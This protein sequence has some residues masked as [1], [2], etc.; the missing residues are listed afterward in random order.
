MSE[1]LESVFIDQDESMTAVIG[2]SYLQNFL[3]GG[4]VE[5][6]VGILTQKRFYYKGTNFGGDG[7][8]MKSTTEEGVVS[9]EDITFTMF[10]HTQ[11]FGL[12]AIGIILALVGVCAMFAGDA[13]AMISSIALAV[14]VLL[15]IIYFA[16]RRTLFWVSFPGGN[17][18]FDIRYYPIADIRDFQR[19]VHLLKDHI[20][21]SA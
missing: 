21:E 8:A 11:D 17:F 19:Q 7:K 13:G 9:I 3:I 12:L 18:G 14:S 20:K 2:T 5:K 16:S 15:F 10:R 6:S 1:P 4:T